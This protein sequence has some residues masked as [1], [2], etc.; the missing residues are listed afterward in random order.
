MSQHSVGDGNNILK[1]WGG[2]EGQFTA[3]GCTDGNDVAAI[4]RAY[5][6]YYFA[7]K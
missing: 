4:F 3:E 1:G 7:A 5:A 6:P 2:G